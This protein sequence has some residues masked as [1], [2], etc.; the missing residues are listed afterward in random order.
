MIGTN[1][2]DVLRALDGIR[3]KKQKFI[4]LNDNMNHS[5]PHS[6]EVVKVLQEFYKS[7]FPNISS[8][9]LPEGQTNKYLYLDEHLAAQQQLQFKKNTI[10][11]F[12]FVIFGLIILLV[13]CFARTARNTSYRQREQ[14]YL[15]LLNGV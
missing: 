11:G 7:L 4:C 6:V 14:R 13:R 15:K 10:Y 8:F 5:N 9:E 3:H 2:T 12:I 1:A